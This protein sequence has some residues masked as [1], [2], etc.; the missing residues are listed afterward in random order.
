[1]IT[2]GSERVC[3]RDDHMPPPTRRFPIP[4]SAISISAPTAVIQAMGT[5]YRSPP[6]TV[7]LAAGSS[8][9]VTSSRPRAPSDRAATRYGAATSRTP[10]YVGITEVVATA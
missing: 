1:M 8:T 2:A 9:L 7:G 5:A 6:S 10:W 3:I 4:F